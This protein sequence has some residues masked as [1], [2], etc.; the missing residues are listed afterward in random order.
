MSV[1]KQK[2]VLR[3]GEWRCADQT[4]ERKL[5]EWTGQWLLSGQAPRLEEPDH[6]LA[7]AREMAARLG[8]RILYRARTAP[9]RAVR[10]F[11]PKRQFRLAFP[12]SE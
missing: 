3:R 7:V 8:G 6:E 10:D 11:F 5:N 12:E 2:A 4:L 9:Q 1:G